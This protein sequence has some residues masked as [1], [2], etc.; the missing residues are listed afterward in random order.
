[1]VQ[2]FPRHPNLPIAILS[3]FVYRHHGTERA[4]ADLL[5]PLVHNHSYEIHLYPQTVDDLAVTM[6]QKSSAGPIAGLT[7]LLHRNSCAYD[8]MHARE[9]AESP[10]SVPLV[11]AVLRSLRSKSLLDAGSVRGRGL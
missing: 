1:M 8:T 6:F 9:N 5:E 4:F 7:S 11:S 3:P 2:L 10:Y